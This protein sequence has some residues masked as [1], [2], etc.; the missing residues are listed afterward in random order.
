MKRKTQ[1]KAKR[2]MRRRSQKTKR[3]LAARLLWRFDTFQRAAYRCERCGVSMRDVM[4]LDPHHLW[5]AGR[6]GPCELWNSCCLCDDC[7]DKIGGHRGRRPVD[8]RE[9]ICRNEAQ[10]RAKRAELDERL[11]K[12]CGWLPEAPGEARFDF[13]G[14]I[15]RWAY[16]HNR[17][18]LPKPEAS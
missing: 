14:V 6:G 2:P 3:A 11:A 5:P 9:W 15:A 8:W 7:H 18:T 16:N 17:T 1:L 4:R 13:E 10:A 12:I